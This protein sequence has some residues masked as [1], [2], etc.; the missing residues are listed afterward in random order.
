M[1]SGAD[2][3]FEK[4]RSFPFSLAAGASV[5]SDCDASRVFLAVGPTAAGLFLTL[6]DI[7]PELGIQQGFYAA[8][9]NFRRFKLRNSTLVTVTGTLFLSNDENFLAWQP[10]SGGG[11]SGTVSDVFTGLSMSHYRSYPWA[12]LWP[13]V[14][15]GGSSTTLQNPVVEMDTGATIAPSKYRFMAEEFNA[16][17]MFKGGVSEYWSRRHRVRCRVLF[18]T[19]NSG[20]TDDSQ[21]AIGIGVPAANPLPAASAIVRLAMV[22]N[23]NNGY[24]F[25]LFVGDGVAT[26]T[27]DL[28]LAPSIAPNVG[29]TMEIDYN[30]PAGYVAGLINGT[31]YGRITTGLP[32]GTQNRGACIYVGEDNTSADRVA[33]A[34]TAMEVAT[35]V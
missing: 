9:G 32:S 1:S 26:T 10:S 33:A 29:Y 21:V 28:T 35:Y 3:I 15:S 12:A 7:G 2:R 18:Y 11:G 31:E 25:R 6:D 17:K 13:A 8:L 5:A 22:L 16:R 23:I 4:A 34:F 30:K 14:G 20:N 24:L 19:L 27:L